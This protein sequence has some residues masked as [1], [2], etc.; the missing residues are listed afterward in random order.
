M[1]KMVRWALVSLACAGLPLWGC[2]AD[3]SPG[4]SGGQAG[5]SAGSGGTAVSTGST[6]GAGGGG[7]GGQRPPDSGNQGG[8]AGTGGQGGR[9]DAAVRSP[10]SGGARP[11]AGAGDRSNGDAAG[12]AAPRMAVADIVGIQGGTVTGK[13][14]FVEVPGGV[15]VTYQLEN[16]PPGLHLTHIHAGTNCNDPG[17][18]GRWDPPRGELID[19]FMCGADRKGSF[20]YTRRGDMANLRWTIGPPQDTD[21][22]GH[23]VVIHGSTPGEV[24]GCGVI[25]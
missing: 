24:L 10:D 4:G 7:A 23:P 19:P 9:A 2:N 6:G 11:D 20:V 16:C 13:L 22:V 21:V 14:T 3:S 25:R 1:T 18:Q 12:S 8:S 5:G 15:Q 17:A